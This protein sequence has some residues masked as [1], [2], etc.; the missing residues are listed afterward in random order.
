M[1][2][3]ILIIYRKKAICNTL[4]ICKF[5]MHTRVQTS[6]FFSTLLSLHYILSSK[7]KRR[8][9]PDQ[10]VI[11]IQLTLTLCYCNLRKIKRSVSHALMTASGC[12]IVSRVALLLCCAVTRRD[13]HLVVSSKTTNFL[14]LCVKLKSL[15]ASLNCKRPLTHFDQKTRFLGLNN[16]CPW[17][18]KD[19]M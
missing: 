15:C 18:K 4:E 14:L 10:S 3:Y 11:N 2:N 19:R 1:H 7:V 9:Y 6:F 17:T 16:Y 5:L 12:C 13:V 8:K